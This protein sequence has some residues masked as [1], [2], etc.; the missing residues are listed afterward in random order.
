MERLKIDVPRMSTYPYH[1]AMQVYEKARRSY[2]GAV[3]WVTRPDDDDIP[4]GRVK[5]F[6][7]AFG[8]VRGSTR[9]AR[10]RQSKTTPDP[11]SASADDDAQQVH[12]TAPALPP[13]RW[14]SALAE[15]K[16]AARAIANDPD[17]SKAVK[18]AT[19]EDL[20]GIQETLNKKP[21]KHKD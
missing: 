18:A 4:D 12:P 9:D 17:A 11:T 6:C 14:N 7:V 2:S 8:I 10:V 13:D 15:L 21:K 16:A 5:N 3:V 19:K 20:K 1:A